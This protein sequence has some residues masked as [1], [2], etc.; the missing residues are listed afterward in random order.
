MLQRPRLCIPF[1]CGVIATFG[2]GDDWDYEPY[3]PEPCLDPDAPRRLPEGGWDDTVKMIEAPISDWR[4]DPALALG[5]TV[6]AKVVI[7][8]AS[9]DPAD[10]AMLRITHVETREVGEI[11]ERGC[12]RPDFDTWFRMTA[13]QEGST[14][15]R[16]R[17]PTGDERQL[18]LRIA[19]LVSGTVEGVGLHSIYVGGPL[20]L[21]HQP[22]CEITDAKSAY[23]DAKDAGNRDL[24]TR[25]TWTIPERGVV[26]FAPFSIFSFGDSLDEY[27]PQRF[28]G[29]H[30]LLWP[31]GRGPV[32]LRVE[33]DTGFQTEVSL[34][35]TVAGQPLSECEDA[36]WF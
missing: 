18:R 26:E 8:D 4:D 25:T 33:T 6:Y 28:V 23:L 21:D 32:T 36:D 11:C 17:G 24:I 10:P 16:V 7:G 13:L 35:V 12:C 22:N 19:E 5:S 20:V 15:L 34:E 1:L 31:V 30:P 2:C 29:P 14:S 27:D 9:V 3:V